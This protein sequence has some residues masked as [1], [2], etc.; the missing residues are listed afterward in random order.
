MVETRER[1]RLAREIHDTLGHAL[2]GI[3]TGIEACTALMDVAPEATKEQLKAIAEV[4]RQGITDVRRS[5]K[6]LRPD[7][8]EKYNLEKALQQTIDEMRTATNAMIDYQC[9]TDL[10]CFNTDEEDVIYRIVQECITNSIRHGKAK[11][12]QISIERE[13]NLMKI[14]IRDNGIGCKD[15][16]RGFGLHHMEE[17][18]NMLHGSL[19]YDGSDGFMVEAQI[20]IRWGNGENI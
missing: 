11:Y 12:I 6:A 1:N 14:C 16:K 2:T 10:N 19:K 17:R 4:A 8:L 15:V 9:T 7:A 13:Y 5:V 3:I 20:P 18:L